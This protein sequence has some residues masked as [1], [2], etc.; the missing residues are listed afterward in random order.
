MNLIKRLLLPALLCYCF[1]GNAQVNT[2]FNNNVPI[3]TEGKFN[4]ARQSKIDLELPQLDIT[5]LHEKEKAAKA[6]SDQTKPLQIAVPVSVD[7]DIAN[8]MNWETDNESAYGKYSIRA[9]GALSASI[10]FDK[11]FLPDG[12]EMYVYNE[13]GNMITGPVTQ[14]ENNK[15]GIWGSWAYKGEYLTIEIKIPIDAKDKLVLHT[16]NI[17]YGYK[18]LYRIKVNDFGAAG[19][20]HI[21]VLCPLGNGWE[22]ERNSV[23]LI[24]DGLG[25]RLCTGSMMMNTSCTSIPYF[26]TADHCFD[27]FPGGWRFTFQAWS[28]TCTPSQN[29][30]GVTFNGS[31]LRA[32]NQASDFCLVE[33][34]NTPPANSNI[35]YAGWNRSSTP[36]TNATGIHHPRGDVMKI[37]RANN[38]VTRGTFFPAF[39]NQ[40]WRANWSAHDNGTGTIVTAVTEPTSSGS[41]LFDQNHRVIGQLSGGP[42][43]C[44]AAAADLWD[45]Y[46][47][48]DLSWTG[49]GTNSTR[50]SNWLDPTSNGATT[51]NTTNVSSLPPSV[52]TLNISGSNTI[53]TSET[54][55][56]TGLPA[57]M[58]VT[59]S[60]Y[61]LSPNYVSLTPNGQSVTANYVSDGTFTLIAT[62]NSC[63]VTSKMIRSGNYS[64]PNISV[65]GPTSVGCG[66][67]VMY[68]TANLPGV[69]YDWY[70]P[71][72]WTLAYGQGTYYV[73]M[74]APSYPYSS[75]PV[76]IGVNIYDVCGYN[77]GYVTVYPSCGS[78]RNAVTH[79]SVSPN[80]A[81]STVTVSVKK[82][83][84][85]KNAN[86]NGPAV[87]GNITEVTI[88]D[89][90][91]AVK[92]RQRFGKT[93]TAVLNVSNLTT[94]IYFIEISDG[95]NKERQQLA[96]L[97]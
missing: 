56:L 47:S 94:G 37:S 57:G 69:Y 40:H 67:Y 22:A 54:Y 50:L 32:R 97:R 65:Y 11:F 74:I 52:P 44:G 72:D 4:K 58:P 35:H 24:L 96:I 77:N 70:Y 87:S 42:S 64:W 10:N 20:C 84:L 61:P 91:G 90:T 41:P 88:Y 25:L 78:F 23:A 68:S 19:G 14:T 85:S 75:S 29:N 17:A 46:G 2:D 33:L 5:A 15:D 34:N 82:D 59:W 48:F 6:A 1:I 81:S 63:H 39:P 43:F 89:Q 62:V 12:A 76:D 53:C 21:N 66:E 30:N 80:P 36:A 92:K 13:N 83:R 26:L 9:T 3:T 31:T 45:V 86:P 93:S 27:G 73:G 55:T 60:V 16:S 71:S 8:R 7:I 51:T 79:Y 18:E 95:V 49:A 38:S 28:P